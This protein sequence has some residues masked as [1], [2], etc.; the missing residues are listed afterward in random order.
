M[1]PVALVRMKAVLY[2]HTIRL[3]RYKWSFLNMILSEAA[4]VF[5]FVLGSLLFVPKEQ[6]TTVVKGA[7]WV[8][9]AWSMISNFS[10]LVGGWMRFF[11]SIGM[12]EE[13][14][15]RGF[16]P[17]KTLLGRLVTGST[18]IISSLLFMAVLV[19][20]AFNVD[21]LT[22]D[23][24]AL[25]IIGMALLAI[26]SLSYGFTVAAISMRTSVPGN[27][28]EILN[29]GVIGLMMIPIHSLPERT[30]LIYLCIPYTAPSHLVKIAISSVPPELVREALILS[31]MVCVTMLIFAILAMKLANLWIK[32]NG[33]KAIG[34]W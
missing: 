8:I 17:F 23:Q 3:W 21:L 34:F 7:F 18:V 28:L 26:E 11:I 31:T 1:K 20:G 16:S 2:L 25:L 14:L 19:K 32:K 29:L 13:H 6:L 24:I 4:W 9:V 33:V 22:V 30:R 10:S 27:L 15:L 12:V 5:L